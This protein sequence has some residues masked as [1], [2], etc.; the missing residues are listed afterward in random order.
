MG[1]CKS[2]RL[3]IVGN[4]LRSPIGVTYEYPFLSDFK[5][6][7]PYVSI[8]QYL[9]SRPFLRSR[10][11][12]YPWLCRYGNAAAI[13]VCTG[14][15]TVHTL[16]LHWVALLISKS[17]HCCNSSTHCRSIGSHATVTDRILVVEVSGIFLTVNVRNERRSSK[18]M[19]FPSDT[20]KE[21]MCLDFTSVVRIHEV[22]SA[23]QTSGG[24]Q[25]VHKFTRVLKR[26]GRVIQ[27]ILIGA[28]PMLL[29]L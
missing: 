3:C 25:F 27:P 23:R 11:H 18:M 2:P 5:C 22:N 12:S 20:A 15:A 1:R 19:S 13:G 4:A 6:L 17:R 16:I 8:P 26:Y 21:P 9:V 10:L 29:V 28:K 14:M 7:L 24:L